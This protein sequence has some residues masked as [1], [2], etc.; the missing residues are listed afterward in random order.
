M[1]KTMVAIACMAF[2]GSAV[3][4]LVVPL[5]AWSAPVLPWSETEAPHLVDATLLSHVTTS[6]EFVNETLHHVNLHD[7]EYGEPI[8][9]VFDDSGNLLHDEGERLQRED[10]ARRFEIVG[11]IHDSLWDVVIATPDD[12]RIPV[13][14]WLKTYESWSDRQAYIED[15]V[16]RLAVDALASAAA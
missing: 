15:E 7:D 3:A 4:P 8:Y 9:L 16:L 5:W 12:V 11:Q 13:I 2:G 10:T 1:T 6:L 14:I